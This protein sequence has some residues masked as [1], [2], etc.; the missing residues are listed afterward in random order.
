MPLPCEGAKS[1][2]HYALYKKPWQYDDVIDGEYFWHYAKRSPFHEQMLE[3]KE[4]FGEGERRMKEGVAKE[5]LEHADQIVASDY[6]FTKILH[7]I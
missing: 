4:N 7:K 1:I 3:A 2:V 6:T 5:I